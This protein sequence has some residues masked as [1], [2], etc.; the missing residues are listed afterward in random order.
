MAC[1]ADSAVQW[2]RERREK[3]RS[4]ML[5][6]QVHGAKARQAAREEATGTTALSP[7][8]VEVDDGGEET[9]A[10]PEA[11][12]VQPVPPPVLAQDAVLD[13][14]LLPLDK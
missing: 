6:R 8:A 11:Q 12:P 13:V 3:M 7:H 10:P 1:A 14:P 4:A 9:E 5:M 2:T